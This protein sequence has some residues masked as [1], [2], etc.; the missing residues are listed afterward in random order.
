[1]NRS[2]YSLV[3]MDEVIKAV[4]R[5]AYKQGTSRSNLINQI[6]ADHLS[7]ETPEMH[8]RSIFDCLSGLMGECF[9]VQERRSASLLTMRTALDYKYRPTISYKVE[10]NRSPQKFIGTLCVSIRTQ[11]AKL[12]EMFDNFFLYWT[13]MEAERLGQ[14]G[15]KECIC[16]LTPVTFVRKLLNTGLD[17]AQTAEA[18]SRYLDG[19]NRALQTYF[20]DPSCLRDYSPWLEAHY[21]SMLEK[22]II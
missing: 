11:S 20:S 19:L 7:C 9:R 15:F 2:V 13:A 1:M 16:E 5:E 18:I 3:L 6:L 22:Y 12:F 4:D 10:L 8:M 21:K 17:D 14:L